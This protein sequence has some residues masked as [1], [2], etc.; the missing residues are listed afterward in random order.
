MSISTLHK[1]DYD[2]DNNN[3]NNNN[4]SDITIRDN[5][6]ATCKLIDGAIPEHRNVIKKEDEKFLKYKKHNLG[7][8]SMLRRGGR[9]PLYRWLGGQQGRSGRVR[10]I[11]PPLRDSI[12]GPAIPTAPTRPTILP[13]LR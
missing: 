1:G 3:N 8:W 12:P 4:N 13:W 2:D 9:Y 7:G 10:K 11:S 6:Q 5:K